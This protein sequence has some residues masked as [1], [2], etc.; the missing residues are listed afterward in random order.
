MH[1]L[2]N[3][4]LLFIWRR[5]SLNIIFIVSHLYVYFHCVFIVPSYI[6][7]VLI[8]KKK[9]SSSKEKPK[10]GGNGFLLFLR[11]QDPGG[12]AKGGPFRAPPGTPR[13][14]RNAKIAKSKNFC[15]AL[16]LRV[17]QDQGFLLLEFKVLGCC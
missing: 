11:I 7:C 2:S 1:V 15:I 5:A 10:N 8:N 3:C 13:D 12:G 4:S 6:L 14:P 16:F 17:S 9:P